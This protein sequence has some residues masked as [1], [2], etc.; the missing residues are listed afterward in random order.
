MLTDRQNYVLKLIARGLERGSPPTIREIQHALG[1]RSPNTAGH[2]VATLV[3][4]GCIAR[5]GRKSRGLRLLKPIPR[6]DC[7]IRFVGQT[8]A[9]GNIPG[10]SRKS[11]THVTPEEERDA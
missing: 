2:I 9:N 1:A 7:L 5:D 3:K 11:V 6:Q 4:K 8:D 10:L